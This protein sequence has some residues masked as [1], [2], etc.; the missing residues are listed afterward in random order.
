M[1]CERSS[2]AGPL[3]FHRGTEERLLDYVR[4][5]AEKG[6]LESVIATIDRFCWTEHWMMNLGDQ[7]GEIYR[8]ALQ[9]RGSKSGLELGV[10]CGY[11]ILVALSAMGEGSRMVGI[12]PNIRTN[13]IAWSICDFAGVSDRVT[14]MQ[15]MLD[16]HLVRLREFTF[17]HVFID[18]AKDAYLPDLQRLLDEKLLKPGTR[19]IADNVV[20]FK[21]DEY[22]GWVESSGR[23]T[24]CRLEKSRLEYTDEETAAKRELWDGVHIGDLK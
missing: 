6:N 15:G 23:F 2:E 19:V 24:G 3:A 21:L 4:E 13:G 5:H 22:I 16:D 20:V 1:E 17:D 8:T 11:S 18:H 12:D 14:I 10:Y 7:K 9:E